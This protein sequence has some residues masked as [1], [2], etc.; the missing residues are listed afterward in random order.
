MVGLLPI[1]APTTYTAFFGTY[2]LTADGYVFYDLGIDE[3]VSG[4]AAYAADIE[5]DIEPA[6]GSS[7]YSIVATPVG[8]NRVH[9][10]VP[11]PKGSKIIGQYINGDSITHYISGLIGVFYP[12]DI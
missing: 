12:G 6:G 3:I 9:G 1:A 10:T 7:Y 11:L 4:A 5:I 2:T 8:P